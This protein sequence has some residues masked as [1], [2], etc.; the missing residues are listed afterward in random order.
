MIVRGFLV[1]TVTILPETTWRTRT[2]KLIRFLAIVPLVMALNLVVGTGGAHGSSDDTYD[3]NAS[4]WYCTVGSASCNI[5]TAMAASSATYCVDGAETCPGL[6]FGAVEAAGNVVGNRAGTPGL[7]VLS[8]INYRPD[9]SY[10]SGYVSVA[11]TAFYNSFWEPT[12][13]WEFSSGPWY[14][15]YD[16]SHI[17][18]Y[19]AVLNGQETW[20]DSTSS[21]AVSGYDYEDNSIGTVSGVQHTDNV[22]DAPLSGGFTITIRG[23]HRTG[24]DEGLA[25][26]S[27]SGQLNY[28][29]S[30]TIT[31]QVGGPHATDIG[32]FLRTTYQN[33]PDNF[34]ARYNCS[35]WATD[36]YWAEG[37]I[38]DDPT[39]EFNHF[40][41][42]V[43]VFF[44]NPI[45][46]SYDTTG[47][48][49]VTG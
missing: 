25:N 15:P 41:G 8:C 1:I 34:C 22:E 29:Y 44:R 37:E 26:Y 20:V 46:V 7:L 43:P 9:G 32:T 2:V 17:S 31:C 48:C 42:W 28:Y 10:N 16:S 30:G 27:S 36:S 4:N 14:E 12:T 24:Y 49:G 13:A 40:C 18:G 33:G 35:P 5:S 19:A 38:E 45:Y 39:Y 47:S 6:N 11:T 3:I 21:A 23:T